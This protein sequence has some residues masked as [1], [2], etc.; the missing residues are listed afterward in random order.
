MNIPSNKTKIWLLLT[1]ISFT[2]TGFFVV[3]TQHQKPHLIK[4]SL[5][6]KETTH[7][8]TWITVFVHGIMSI[9]PHISLNNCVLFMRDQIQGTVY[10]KAVSIMR[11]NDFFDKNQ[12]MQRIGFHP[13][14]L[15][16]EDLKHS[17]SAIAHIFDKETK[18]YLS[19][20]RTDYYYTFGWSA[21]MSP[22]ARRRDASRFFKEL[23]AEVESFKKRGIH[24]KIRLIG[25]SHGGNICLNLAKVRR[26]CY[27]ESKLKI[28]QLILFGTP[29]QTET[30]HLVSDPL[31]EKVYNFYSDADRIQ[32]IDFFAFNRLFSQKM[33]KNRR[34]FRVPKKLLQ[35]NLKLMRLT[36][37]DPKNIERYKQLARNTENESIIS[38]TNRLLRD[39]SPGHIELWFFGWAPQHYRKHFIFNPLPTLVMLPYII[40]NLERIDF[41]FDSNNPIIFDMRPELEQAIIKQYCPKKFVSVVPF[42]SQDDLQELVD[43][44]KKAQPESYTQEEYDQH[45]E[46]ALCLAKKEYHTESYDDYQSKPTRMRNKKRCHCPCNQK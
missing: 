4:T 19:N 35:V 14:S 40:A 45:I 32:P 27:K 37:T 33:F 18:R 31:F 12:A 30:D 42:P 17:T 10:E 6:K 9:K 34:Q 38:G 29:I 20:N 22:S 21:L 25:Y 2:I 5:L 43:I 23:E 16:E 39:V 13:I 1:T 28:D 3:D 46:E 24:P 26:D 7:S 8:E 36:K 44:A 15:K 11:E 41:E